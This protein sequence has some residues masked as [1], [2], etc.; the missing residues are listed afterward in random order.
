MDKSALIRQALDQAYTYEEYAKLINNLVA[1]KKTSGQKQSEKLADITLLNQTRMERLDNTVE[2]RNDLIE[3]AASLDK[4][5]IWLVFTEAWC[6]DAAQN[7]PVINKVAEINPLIQL[8]L[9]LRDEHPELMAYYLTDGAYAI[10]KLVCFD[11]NTMEE[12][13][14]WGPRPKEAQDIVKNNKE[15]GEKSHDQIVKDVQLW[16]A[17]DKN[18]SIQKE[19][20]DF[21]KVLKKEEVK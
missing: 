21:I 17:R 19:L 8:R 2:L 12:L 20:V 15:S 4:E 14:T 11:G 5:L 6:G 10:P 9:V 7:L 16:Y 3:A 13:A 1:H 18:K